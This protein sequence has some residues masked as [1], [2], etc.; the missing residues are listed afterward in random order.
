MKGEKNKVILV[1]VLMLLVIGLIVALTFV[2]LNSNKKEENHSSSANDT[3][4]VDVNQFPNISEECTFNLAL[5]EYN[6]LTGPRCKNG[7]SRYNVTGLSLNGQTINVSVIYTDQAGNKAGIYVNDR[8][9]TTVVN[10]V[11]N[12][13]FSV[14]D[15]KLFILDNNNN[16]SNVLVFASDSTKVYDLKETLESSSITDPALNQVLSS[17]TINPNSFNFTAANFTFQAQLTSD[18]Q[19]LA[20]STYQVT[21]TGNEFSKPEFVS[22]S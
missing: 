17:S 19:V 4:T 12:I 11:T 22:M 21:F 8:R 16:E 3:P 15:N 18:N 14:F 7:Y 10:D 13:K 20:G 1:Y 2:V 9:A 5:D 6:A